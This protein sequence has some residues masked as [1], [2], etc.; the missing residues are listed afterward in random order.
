[1]DTL[2]SSPP[3]TQLSIDDPVDDHI[4]FDDISQHWCEQAA[5]FHRLN[6]KVYDLLVFYAR[7]ARDAGRRRVGIELLWNRMRWDFMVQTERTDE[8][9]LNQN[10]KAWYA[11][12]ILQ[13]EPDLEGIFE[14][15]RRRGEET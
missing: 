1:M 6:P 15:R 4:V 8:F 13:L 14:L 11:R 5:E 7:Q 10:L 9:K 2:I 3:V 12:R